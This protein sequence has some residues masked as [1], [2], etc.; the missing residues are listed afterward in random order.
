MNKLAWPARRT[1]ARTSL[2][3]SLLF[4]ASLPFVVI[5]NAHADDS[6]HK[7][8][9]IGSCSSSNCHGNVNPVV[10]GDVL[11]NEYVTWQKHDKHA[12]AF[13]VLGNEQ[14][15]TIAN[16]LG[17]K[18]AQ[19]EPLCLKCHSTYVP[20]AAD[21]GEKFQQEDGVGCETCHGPASAWLS[22]HTSRE[23]THQQNVEHGL[24]DLVG[25]SRRT[26]LCLS[27][28]HGNEEKTVDHR[29]IAAGHPRLTVE[30]DTFESIMPRHAPPLTPVA[31]RRR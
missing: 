7:Y 31:C 28:H 23:A 15:R 1:T 12:H 14:S 11:Q 6:P 21:R 5:G 26:Q 27:C 4:F 2:T 16:H 17:I 20:N 9:G 24:A 10:T 13:S 25:L 3:T 22:T 18:S 29:L 8:M 30:L 19:S